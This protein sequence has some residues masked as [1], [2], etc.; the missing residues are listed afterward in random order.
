MPNFVFVYHGG[1]IDTN[2]PPEEGKKHQEKF[3][4]W[5]KN[6]GSDA[7]KPATPLGPTK[8]VSPEGISDGGGPNPISGFSVIKAADL[9]AAVEL[10]KTCPFLDIGGTIGVS[11]EMSM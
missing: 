1:N 4:A 10:A 5:V 8:M 7:V 9:D 11:E 3:I 2:M 6:L